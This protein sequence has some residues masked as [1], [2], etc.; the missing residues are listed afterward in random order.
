LLPKSNAARSGIGLWH[1]PSFDSG[2][3][4]GRKCDLTPRAPHT[5]PIFSGDGGNLH[6]GM[7]DFVGREKKEKKGKKRRKKPPW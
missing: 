4:R 2:K 7:E 6:K 3:V 5:Q 1:C